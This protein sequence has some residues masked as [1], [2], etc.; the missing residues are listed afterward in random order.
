MKLG[1]TVSE[2]SERLDEILGRGRGGL[3]LDLSELEYADSTAVGVLVGAQRRFESNGRSLV[4]VNPKERISSLLRVT[5]LDSLFRIHA[6]V[7][8]A[9]ASL[10]PAREEEE[11]REH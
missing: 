1:E 8:E 6:T 10:P 9:L 4:L 2:F 3:V 5:H 7:E 11:T